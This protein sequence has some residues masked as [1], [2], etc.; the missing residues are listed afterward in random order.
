MGAPDVHVGPVVRVDV[1]E[2][3]EELHE[4]EPVPVR[5]EELGCGGVGAAG[6]GDRPPHGGHVADRLATEVGGGQGAERRV[7]DER[8][9]LGVGQQ[10]ELVQ[11]VPRCR[12]RRRVLDDH[13]PSDGGTGG[14]TSGQGGEGVAA[15]VGQRALEHGEAVPIDLRSDLGEVDAGE[16]PGRGLGRRVRHLLRAAQEAS[17]ELS[18]Q[19]RPHLAHG[20]VG[21]SRRR[22]GE[23]S[24]PRAKR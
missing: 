12:Q 17:A 22:H 8:L 18:G 20:A 5:V 9:D 3:H 15:V 24:A 10:V 4:G 23:P 19:V 16:Q 21:G 7:D 14:G 2:V 6:P 11:V 1:G 13:R